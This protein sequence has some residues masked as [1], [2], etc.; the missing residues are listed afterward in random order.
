VG[1]SSGEKGE[2]NFGVNGSRETRTR[3]K[4]TREFVVKGGKKCHFW[5]QGEKRGGGGGVTA[6]IVA[7]VPRRTKGEVSK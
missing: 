5:R 2:P 1:G 7:E 4:L 6:V 3:A